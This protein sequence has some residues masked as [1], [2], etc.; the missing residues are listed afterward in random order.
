MS[1]DKM[2]KFKS[3]AC[4]EFFEDDNSSSF[5][6]FNSSIVNLDDLNVDDEKYCDKIENGGE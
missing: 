5:V 6:W 1:E 2:I 4:I 3:G